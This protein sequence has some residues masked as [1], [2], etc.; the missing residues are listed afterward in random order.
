[1]IRKELETTKPNLFTVRKINYTWEI[2]FP[3][4]SIIRKKGQHVPSV[5]AEMSLCFADKYMSFPKSF[6]P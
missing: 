4:K 5:S 2:L 6:I 3:D 1:M